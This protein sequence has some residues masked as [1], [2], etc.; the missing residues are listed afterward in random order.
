MEGTNLDS[1]SNSSPAPSIHPHIPHLTHFTTSSHTHLFI[2]TPSLTPLHFQPH[3]IITYLS[4]HNYTIYPTQLHDYTH[5]YSLYSLSTHTCPYTTTQSLT[6]QHNYTHT[7]PYIFLGAPRSEDFKNKNKNLHI[8]KFLTETNLKT[9]KYSPT[10][11]KFSHITP[12]LATH[13]PCIP[14]FTLPGCGCR[15]PSGHVTSLSHHSI[16]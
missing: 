5:T 6:Q 3:L 12:H 15:P 13:A 2:T 9:V 8:N 4:L 1:L 16:C 7:Y 11:D 10:T 14:G